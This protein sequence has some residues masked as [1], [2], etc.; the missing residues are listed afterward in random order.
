MEY[1]QPVVYGKHKPKGHPQMFLNNF[2]IRIPQGKEVAGG[3]VELG[4][5][6]HYVLVLANKN[7]QRADARVEIDGKP[8]GTFRI[9]AYGTITLERP[10][11]DTGKFTFYEVGSHEANK[12]GLSRS[13]PNLGLVSVVFTPEIERPPVVLTVAS[14]YPKV[15]EWTTMDV[16]EWSSNAS[17]SAMAASANIHNDQVRTYSNTSHVSSRKAG[18][19]GLSGQ[20]N[21]SFVNVAPLDYD[22]SRQTTIHLRLVSPSDPS[23]EPR[24]LTAFSTPIPPMV[25]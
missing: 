1:N 5:G 25:E 23:D 8:V 19:T 16:S 11:H 6:T 9:N 3:Y 18:G 20:S 13:N 21:Q 10:V 2:S 22:L 7:A 14:S 12:I 24:P 17:R 15:T 4:H